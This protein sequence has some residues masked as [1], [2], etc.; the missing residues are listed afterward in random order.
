MCYFD[1]QFA[2]CSHDLYNHDMCAVHTLAYF[3]TGDMKDVITERGLYGHFGGTLF[4][5]IQCSKMNF[6]LLCKNSGIC[7][8]YMYFL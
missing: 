1:N 4:V 5:F 2:T 7:I 6:C 3:Q 8:E